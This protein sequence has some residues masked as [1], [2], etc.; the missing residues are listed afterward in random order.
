MGKRY[1]ISLFIFRRDLR[2]DDNTALRTVL[3]SSD[4]VIP[5]F[6]FDPQQVRNNPYRGNN[7]MQFMLESLE[8]LDKQLTSQGGRLYLFEGEPAAVID[9]LIAQHQI[10]AVFVNRDYTP[11]S[12][13][14]DRSINEI[15]DQHSVAFHQH[16]DALLTEPEA[17]LKDDGKPYTVYT[18]FAK[19]ARTI[20]IPE[21]QAVS[22][23]NF[24]TEDIAGTVRLTDLPIH[25]SRNESLFTHGGS[26][27]AISQLAH[28][29]TFRDYATTRDIPSLNATTGLSAHLKFGTISVR[30]VYRSIASRFGESHTLI[31]ELYWRDFFTHIAFHFPHI[32]TGAFH[33]KYD[34]LAW[35]TD[36]SAFERWCS[37]TTGFPIV[38][39]G[40]RQL[41][42]TGFMHNRVRMIV[43]S[44]LVKDLHLDW[45]WGEKYFAQ[46]LSDYDP[47]VNN[48]NWQWAASTGCD[49]APYFRIF[50]PWLQQKKF[51]PD[52]VYIHRWIP[53]LALLSPS[54]IHSLHESNNV[55]PGYP[56][57]MVDHR[58]EAE[59]SK[60]IFASL[61]QQLK[62]TI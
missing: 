17:V 61:N 6:I 3:E 15:C 44:F 36:T 27:N 10:N 58:I 47:S 54:Q 40:M 41:N 50:N 25:P 32:F 24:H 18:P 62:G 19:R 23:R 48:G 52:C 51:D 60:Q 21:P 11:Y 55:T 7:A 12:I 43:A 53:E 20:L 8:W 31:N 34:Q 2:L 9:Q 39:A 37:G 38:D 29:D 4:L 30:R 35:S 56:S 13:A 49:A 14:R 5:C 59:R 16:A 26:D 28:L 46:K 45:H 1:H 42:Q 57:P 22:T 33:A